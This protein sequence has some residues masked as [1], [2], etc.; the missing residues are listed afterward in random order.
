MLFYLFLVVNMIAVIAVAIYYLSPPPNEWVRRIVLLFFVV[1]NIT[2]AW[3]SIQVSIWWYPI[4]VEWLA[5][6]HTLATC[7]IVT[8]STVQLWLYGKGN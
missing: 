7:I 8:L 3:W 2:F 4:V 5:A 1:I 6:N